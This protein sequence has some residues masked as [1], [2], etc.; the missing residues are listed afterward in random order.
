MPFLDQMMV[1][2]VL[3]S[4]VIIILSLL[5]KRGG[6]GLELSR[7]I[8]RTDKWFNILSIIII[9]IFSAIY[10]LFW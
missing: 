3:I 9:I 7:T 6:K 5:D 4:L 1:S 10:I 8:F 2:F